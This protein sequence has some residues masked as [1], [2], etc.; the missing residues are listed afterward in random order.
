MSTSTW[1]NEARF[2]M[3]IHWGPYSVAARGEWVMNRERIPVEEYR[4]L[5][6][7]TFTADKYDPYAWAHLARQAGMKYVVLTARHHDGFCLWNT[8]TTD[9]NAVRMGAKRDLVAP[10][11]EAVRTAGLK[12]GLYYSMADWSHPDYPGAF[13]RD[14]P[15]AWPD[16]AAR[17]RFVDFY[18]KQL[19]ELLTRYGPI[20]MLWYDGCIPVPTDGAAVNARIKEL[21]PQILINN[22]NGEPYDFYC[23]EQTI[24]PAAPGQDWEACMTLNGN[25]GYHAGDHGWKTARD[26]A[27]LL[28]ETAGGG[29]NLLLNVGP[30][31][32]GSLPSETEE[33]LVEVGKWLR[34][35]GEFLPN[36]TRSPFTWLNWGKLTT[37]G[38]TVYAHIFSLGQPDLCIAEIKNVVRGIRR[39]D[40]GQP[41]TFERQG[42]RLFLHG[43]PVTQPGQ[44]PLVLAIDVE[45]TPEPIT[46]QGTFWIPE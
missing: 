16:E 4:R 30:R 24:K 13:Q 7:E 15:T 39:C 8:A 45:G 42:N 5:Y 9:A 34:T 41:V 25:W 1:F 11:V 20:D 18:R 37:K 26:V 29:G 10:F 17:K 32:D 22:R 21:Q 27:R 19:D 14:W 23:C 3:F 28:V 38:N 31:G 46:E 36:S 33:I 44:M 35:N 12:V 6:C 2:G 40:N 43:L